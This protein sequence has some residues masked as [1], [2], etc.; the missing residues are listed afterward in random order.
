MSLIL[1]HRG[2]SGYAP[3]NTIAAFNLAKSMGAD[4]F[5][6]DVHL[7]SDNRLVVIH[8]ET[9]DRTTDGTGF[10]GL[11]TFSELKALDASYGK[12]NYSNEKIPELVE[13]LDIIQ[14][15]QM[16]INIEIKTDIVQYSGIE[17]KCFETVKSMG[18]LDQIIF[19]SFNHYS[20]VKLRALSSKAK[21]GVLYSDGLYEPWNYARLLRADYLHPFWPNIHFP[22][23]ISDSLKMGIGINAWTVND[24]KNMRFCL[25][26][27][28]GLITNYPDKAIQ[29]KAMAR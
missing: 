19:S 29:E 5:E 26:N 27:N 3:E 6:L 28:V 8:D 20:L 1:A 25:E 23:Y 13:V 12:P 22:N 7:S 9:L 10:V 4:G 16:I 14:G 15:T 11:K 21:I 2:A 18:L 17:E 24:T